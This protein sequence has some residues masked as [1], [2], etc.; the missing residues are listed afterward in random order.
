MANIKIRYVAGQSTLEISPTSSLNHGDTVTIKGLPQGAH[1]ATLSCSQTLFEGSSP[2]DVHNGKQLTVSS[3][4]SQGS[5]TI[6][7]TFHLHENGPGQAEQ[8]ATGTLDPTGKV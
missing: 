3:H 4:A 5:D 8:T 6:T 1:N 2:Y 7:L